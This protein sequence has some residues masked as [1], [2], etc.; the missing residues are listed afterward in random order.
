MHV[1]LIQQSRQ[2]HNRHDLDANA[3]V[4]DQ[5]GVNGWS[6]ILLLTSAEEAL[7]SLLSIVKCQDTT[8]DQYEIYTSVMRCSHAPNALS[9]KSK[10]S[11]FQKRGMISSGGSPDTPIFTTTVMWSA[12]LTVRDSV[13]SPRTLA[14]PRSLMSPRVLAFNERR[15]FN[16]ASSSSYAGTL[17][18]DSSDGTRKL[19]PPVNDTYTVCAP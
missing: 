14:S 16:F 5:E 8:A 17:T 15:A 18:N 6:V 12:S 13:A 9:C 1:E 7:T 11:L 2:E 19:A 10:L 3:E 4:A